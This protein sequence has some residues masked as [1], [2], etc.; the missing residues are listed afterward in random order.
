MSTS[1]GIIPSPA[2]KKSIVAAQGID[3]LPGAACR[4]GFLAISPAFPRLLS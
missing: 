1:L 4:A 2:L 3:P